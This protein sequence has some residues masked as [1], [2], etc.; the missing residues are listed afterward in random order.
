MFCGLEC[1]EVGNAALYPRSGV[2]GRAK[3][4]VSIHCL[5]SIKLR[6]L[7]PFHHAARRRLSPLGDSNTCS[8]Q[9]GIAI[10]LIEQDGS[11]VRVLDECILGLCQA[12]SERHPAPSPRIRPSKFLRRTT[13]LTLRLGQF[14][15]YKRL[16]MIDDPGS[17]KPFPATQC[18]MRF[19][20]S[21]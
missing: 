2:Y 17:N 15:L 19:E 21:E 5:V 11:P 20:V 9:I 4:L 14:V 1:T 3:G 10:V 6:R 16:R 13:P 8:M 7:P 12:V 18:T